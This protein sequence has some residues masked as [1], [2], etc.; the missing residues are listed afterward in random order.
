MEGTTANFGYDNAQ[1]ILDIPDANSV[2]L[3]LQAIHITAKHKYDTLFIPSIFAAVSLFV[4][5]IQ[6]AY[7]KW[8]RSKGQES[9]TSEAEDELEAD[10]YRQKEEDRILVWN[11]GRCAACVILLGISVWQAVRGK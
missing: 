9:V 8:I 6:Y 1:H 7:K 11:I 3:R 5:L 10:E 2:T 4:I